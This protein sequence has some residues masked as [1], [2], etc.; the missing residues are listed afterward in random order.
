MRE[1]LE[2]FDEAILLCLMVSQEST[3]STIQERLKPSQFLDKISRK[4]LKMYVELKIK[5]FSHAL[6]DE[7]IND[8][9]GE[10]SE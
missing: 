9:K 10:P 1:Y 8:E 3:P 6:V 2:W 7:Y 5:A 4:M